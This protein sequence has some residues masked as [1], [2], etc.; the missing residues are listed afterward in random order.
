MWLM[1]QE[2]EMNI[3]FSFT[4]LATA[5]AILLGGLAG[6]ESLGKNVAESQ[7]AA[8]ALELRAAQGGKSFLLLEP[9]GNCQ[10][11]TIKYEGGEFKFQA[12]EKLVGV[13]KPSGNVEAFGQKCHNTVWDALR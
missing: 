1:S 9:D 8:A 11:V 3:T 13:R 6:W 5:A 12:Q 2:L 7:L 10:K 4:K